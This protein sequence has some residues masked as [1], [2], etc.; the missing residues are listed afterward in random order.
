M[1]LVFQRYKY[2]FAETYNLLKL[3][4]NWIRTDKNC[5]FDCQIKHKLPRHQLFGHKNW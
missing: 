3:G 5:H 2:N 1:R 4:V